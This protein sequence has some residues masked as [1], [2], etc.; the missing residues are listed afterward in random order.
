MY[1]DCGQ[2]LVHFCD[3]QVVSKPKNPWPRNSPY[4]RLTL[5]ESAG[6]VTNSAPSIRWHVPTSAHPIRW[7]CLVTTGWLGAKRCWPCR[8][9]ERV[10]NCLLDQIVRDKNDELSALRS[11]SFWRSRLQGRDHRIADS[12][13]TKRHL[14][15]IQF[16]FS[17]RGRLCQFHP[18]QKR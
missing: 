7:S 2:K 13:V 17:T 9:R 6:A 1:G 16:R 3:S 14:R 11:G 4:I 15:T 8:N 10:K 5:N 12:F 18:K